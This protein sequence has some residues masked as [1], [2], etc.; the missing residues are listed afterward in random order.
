M[1]RLFFSIG[2]F[3]YPSLLFEFA[4]ILKR[5]RIAKGKAKALIRLLMR[6][7]MHIRGIR[8][9][10]SKR[11]IKYRV[12]CI[13]FL[14]EFQRCITSM[15]W[16]ADLRSESYDSWKYI[17]LHFSISVTNMNIRKYIGREY[18]SC[19]CLR[20]MHILS[21]R[22]IFNRDGY[23]ECRFVS[24]NRVNPLKY[25]T[26]FNIYVIDVFHIYS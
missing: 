26:F 22:M 17:S 16:C 4:I 7:V 6:H 15:Y 12:I 5:K 14:M 19:I 8:Y 25:R 9:R 1:S 24:R 18:S 2:E 3:Y 10:T 20:R 23:W 21:F 13:N 11:Y